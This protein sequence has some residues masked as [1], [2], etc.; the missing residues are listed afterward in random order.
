M[1]HIIYI[2]LLIVILTVSCNKNLEIKNKLEGT[3][4]LIEEIENSQKV[5]E[6]S[7]L[8]ITFE[9]DGSN[10]T[11]GTF[12]FEKDSIV[13]ENNKYFIEEYYSVNWISLDY[14]DNANVSID[15]SLYAGER[16]YQ[17]LELSNSELAISFVSN[18]R[19]SEVELTYI[20]K[21]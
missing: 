21:K 5:Q 14:D 20:F 9:N 19:N 16:E 6:I 18:Q 2:L 12:T 3:W 1:K 17:I 7:N 4:T 8:K 10:S 13:Y 15:R 11:N